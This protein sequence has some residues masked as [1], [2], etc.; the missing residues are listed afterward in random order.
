VVICDPANG[1]PG[2]PYDLIFSTFVYEHL[3]RPDQVLEAGLGAMEAGGLLAIFS[4]HYGMPGYVPPALR[5]LPLSK[6]VAAAVLLAC[7]RQWAAWRRR[8]NFW[9]V[10]EPA[11]FQR[12]YFVDADAVHLVSVAD[13]RALL[14]TRV[15]FLPLRVQTKGL[16]DWVWSRFLLLGVLLRKRQ[17]GHLLAK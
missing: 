7:G 15:D 1:L 13:L 17:S 10:T 12:G 5:A 8:A 16:R 14:G 6:R 9:I 2:R 4:P 3:I 11:L